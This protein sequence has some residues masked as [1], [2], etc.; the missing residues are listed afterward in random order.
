MSNHSA[1]ASP[2][3]KSRTRLH[4]QLYGIE[5]VEI[6][7]AR[8]IAFAWYGGEDV[9]AFC[10]STGRLEK[11]LTLK[12]LGIIWS[13]DRTE[14]KLRVEEVFRCLNSAPNYFAE[15]LAKPQ[16]PQ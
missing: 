15:M 16:H 3:A 2:A 12:D 14:L 9:L 4:Q 8:D 10:C 7:H 6:D 11:Q 1:E 13:L 5:A